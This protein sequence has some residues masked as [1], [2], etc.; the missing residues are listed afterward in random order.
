MIL[1]NFVVC[2]DIRKENNGKAILIGVYGDEIILKDI[3]TEKNDTSGILIPISFFLQVRLEENDTLPESFR[4]TYQ[5]DGMSE[6]KEI[7]GALSK[8]DKSRSLSFI[9]ILKA[10][11][12]PFNAKQIDFTF[13]LLN[14]NRKI[15]HSYKLPSIGVKIL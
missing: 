15:L 10:F 11:T 2:D 9:L 12:L 8:S 3:R 14:E 4:F 1:Q 5:I 6:S 13:D 7:S